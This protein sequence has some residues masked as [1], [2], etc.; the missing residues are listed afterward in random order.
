MGHLN[1]IVEMEGPI[2]DVRARYWAAHREAIETVGFE[3][4]TEN[5]FWR[6]I[7][8]GA[9]DAQFVR[10]AKPDKLAEY[11]Q[12]RDEKLHSSALMALDETRNGA[13]ENL[14]VLKQLGSCHLATLC[15]NR[16]GLNSTLDRLDIWMYFDKKTVLPESRERRVAA[17]K[18]LMGHHPSTLVV[19]GSVPFAY[20]AGEAGG[21][22]VGI[23]G[24]PAFPDRLRQV[25]ADFCFDSLDALTDALAKRDPILER[26]GLIF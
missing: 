25:G 7:R 22:V 6:L 9:P 1:T 16:E 17:L 4:P 15:D 8:L 23:K 3:G 19:A 2:I 11:V 5:E 12:L 26:I 21:R 24:G 18:E 10:H 13:R 14:R 20:A